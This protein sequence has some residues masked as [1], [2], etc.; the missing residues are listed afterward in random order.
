M[1]IEKKIKTIL[2]EM[3]IDEAIPVSISI[4]EDMMHGDYTTNIAFRASKI[5][6]K[7]PLEVAEIIAT[8]LQESFGT[9]FAKIEAV[10]PGFIN[11][12]LSETSLIQKIKDILSMPEKVGKNESMKNKKIMVEFTDP[13]P[14]KEFHIGHLYSNTVGES[15]CRILEAQGATVKRANYQGDVGL[16]VAKALWAMRQLHHEMPKD[17]DSLQKQ[18]NFMGKA[19]AQGATA[20]EEDEQAK[21]EIRQLNKKI[22]E[23]D[24]SIMELYTKGKKWSMEYFESIYMRLGMGFDYYYPESKAGTIGLALVKQHIDDGIFEEDKG[25]IIFRGEKYGLHTRVFINSLGLPTYEA[26]ELGLAP[27]KYADF[28]YDLSLIITANEIDEYFKVLLQA[29][30]LVN[31]EL[32]NKTMHMSHGVVRLPEGKMSSRTGKI[33]TGEW[34]LDEAHRRAAEKIAETKH[35]EAKVPTPEYDSV[36]EEVGIGAIKYAFLK[37]TVG[38]DIEFSFEDSIS[39]EGNSGPYLQ[40]SFVRT[41]SILKKG[42]KRLQIPEN[43]KLNTDEATLLRRLYQFDR[44]I[45]EAGESFAPSIIASYLYELAKQ[46]SFFYQSNRIADAKKEEETAFR[47]A[48]TNAVGMVLERGL[49]IL[50]IE[51]PRHM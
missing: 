9:D 29:L 12:Y 14:F 22:Y 44:I 25:A 28:P 20:Y 19:Y 37:S 3:K 38:K 5:L 43:Y 33:V 2:G 24:A 15:I 17:D 31:P 49:H 26:K 8:K 40:Y 27:T 45:V 36:S 48:L 6:K 32:G 50:G 41:Q 46:F 34:L 39:F 47:I 30:K 23:E 13:N 11:F 42:K 18:V 7:S 16:H 51:S 21:E 10:K 4:P 1:K 35:T